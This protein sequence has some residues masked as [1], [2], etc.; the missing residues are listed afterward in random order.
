MLLHGAIV[1]PR[2]ALEAVAEVVKAVDWPKPDSSTESAP[3]TRKGIFGRLGGKHGDAA[4]EPVVARDPL[5]HVDVDRM[6]LPIAGFGNVTPGDVEQIA[7][8][9]ADAATG[10]APA[11]VRF[12]GGTAL[13]FPGDPC[14]WARL[15]GDVDALAKIARG[16]NQSVERLGFFVDRRMFRPML[17]LATVNEATTGPYLQDLVDALDAFRGEDWTVDHVSLL[18]LSFVDKR[19]EEKEFRRIPLAT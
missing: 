14:V 5:D 7:E 3:P 18:K 4:E 13:D 9:I 11:R 10:W 8:A 19:P 17:S 6:Y 2:T 12:A 16:V 15:D 1:P